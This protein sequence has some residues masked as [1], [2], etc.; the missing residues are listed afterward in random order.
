MLP[1]SVAP[2]SGCLMPKGISAQVSRRSHKVSCYH[3]S[4]RWNRRQVA[5][6]DTFA[7]RGYLTLPWS[8]VPSIKQQHPSPSTSRQHQAMQHP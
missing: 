4:A 1:S 5:P 8:P 3:L 2:V 7:S 6:T